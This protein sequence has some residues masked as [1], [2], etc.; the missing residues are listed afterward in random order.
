MSVFNKDLLVKDCDFILP[1]GYV[2]NEEEKQCIQEKNV[3]L[4]FKD[5]NGKMFVFSENIEGTLKPIHA[6]KAKSNSAHFDENAFD[7]FPKVKINT[8]FNAKESIFKGDISCNFL[9]FK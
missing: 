1:L 7:E 8:A 3:K 6:L 4:K 9:K 5:E 2:L